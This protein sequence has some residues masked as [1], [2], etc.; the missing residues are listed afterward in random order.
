MIPTRSLLA[1]I[2]LSFPIASHAKAAPLTDAQMV[3]II[4]TVNEGEILVA[5]LGKQSDEHSIRNFAENMIEQHTASN[6]KYE[7]FRVNRSLSPSASELSKTLKDESTASRRDL[8]HLRGPAFNKA[9][10]DHQIKA[11]SKVLKL[12]DENIIPSV[13]DNQ[14]KDLLI[15]TRFT[16]STHLNHA[17]KLLSNIKT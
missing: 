6:R 9:Y 2:A 5:H 1:A 7:Q 12:L 15:E 3:Q 16:V 17:K 10:V 8:S 13:Q 11:H 4:K 14:L